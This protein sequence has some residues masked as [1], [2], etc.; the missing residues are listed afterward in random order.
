[1]NVTVHKKVQDIGSEKAV[2]YRLDTPTYH[3]PQV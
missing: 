2:A 1:M 3:N